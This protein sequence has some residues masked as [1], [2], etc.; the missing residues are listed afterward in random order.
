MT[1]RLHYSPG[2][3]SL[4]VHIVLEELG[5]PY[6]LDARVIAKG[7]TQA[8]DYLA[9]N[10][11]GRVPALEVPGQA[12]VLTELPAIMA[13]LARRY[14]EA[15]LVPVEPIEEARCH[16]LLSWLAGWVHGMGWTELWRPHR[17]IGEPAQYEA[18]MANGRRIIDESSASIE[19]MLAATQAYG[20][21]DRFSIADPYLLAIYRWVVR[22]GIDGPGR[23]PAWHAHALRLGERPAVQRALDQEGLTLLGVKP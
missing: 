7:A 3:C 8:A 19:A 10:P 21:G 11:K 17:F 1:Y 22:I 15:G 6:T 14:P 4:A 12:R 23:Y 20:T 16:E 5:V 13:Y 9:V 18:V 2:A